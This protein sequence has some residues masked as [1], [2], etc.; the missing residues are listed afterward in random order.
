MNYFRYEIVVNPEI[1]EILLAFLSE[2]PFDTFEETAKG[3]NAFLPDKGGQQEVE[4][5]LLQLKERFDFSWSAHQIPYQNWNASWESSFETIIVGSFCG[6][7][8]DFHE[9]L[10]GL[11]HEIIINPKMAFGTGHH[12]TTYMMIQMM[13]KLDLAGTKVLDYGSGTGI[14]SILASKMGANMV[15][16]VDIETQAYENALENIQ[17]NNADHIQVVLGTLD[18]VLDT[19]YHVI[20]AN[21]NRNVI[22]DSLP[23]L[24]NKL[25]PGGILLIS[26]VLKEDEK[27]LLDSTA[28]HGFHLESQLQRDEW[29]CIQLLRKVF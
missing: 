25:N 10:S 2:L 21:I 19:G 9:P 8:A 26:G 17:A 28:V 6:I 16:A 13:E 15:D 11:Q 12:A 1:A 29:V 3:L 7:R 4:A 22:L 23:T 18:N 5:Q 27:L 14:L 20:L 24:Y